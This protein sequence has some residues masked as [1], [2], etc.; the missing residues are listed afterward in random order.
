MEVGGRRV[1]RAL[2]DLVDI[3]KLPRLGLAGT[4]V[5]EGLSQIV[6]ALAWRRGELQAVRDRLQES[7]GT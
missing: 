3:E 7:V 5:L 6:H 2:F 1:E 4:G